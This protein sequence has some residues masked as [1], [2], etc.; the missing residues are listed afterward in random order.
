[1]QNRLP[2][3]VRGKDADSSIPKSAARSV[4]SSGLQSHMLSISISAEGVASAGLRSRVLAKITTDR[5]GEA[6]D[7][8]GPATN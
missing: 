4:Q 5:T 2:L 8:A 6:D 1:M 3:L 7:D